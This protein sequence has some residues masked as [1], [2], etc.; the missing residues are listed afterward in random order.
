MKEM[1]LDLRTDV[2]IRNTILNVFKNI[3]NSIGISEK[4]SFSIKSDF[5]TQASHNK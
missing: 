1:K 5:E 2:W 4:L 3:G